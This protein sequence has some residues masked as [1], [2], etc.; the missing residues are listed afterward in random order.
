MSGFFLTL[1]VVEVR[2]SK[3]GLTVHFNCNFDML[4]GKMTS[5]KCIKY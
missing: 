3:C 4:G 2:E 1:A 5:T